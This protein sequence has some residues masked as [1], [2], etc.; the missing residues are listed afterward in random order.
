[1]RL[2]GNACETVSRVYENVPFYRNAFDKI[3][4]KPDD[5]KSLDDLK[6]LPLQIKMIS[7]TIIPTAYLPFL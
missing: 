5:I 4:L 3:G 7:M 6:K 1:M 2:Q